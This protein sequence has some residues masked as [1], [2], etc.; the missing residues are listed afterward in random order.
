MSFCF[1]DEQLEPSGLLRLPEP[2]SRALKL[3]MK[4][5][6]LRL[7]G[8]KS[9]ADMAQ[10]AGG[11]T[12]QARGL[13]VKNK[14]LNTERLNPKPCRPH[15]IKALAGS[16]RLFLRSSAGQKFHALSVESR[17]TLQIV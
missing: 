9:R 8:A 2:P 13:N 16:G 6:T 17:K 15:K 10:C 4:P 1:G 3:C 12:E 14:T 5:W 7:E 11:H